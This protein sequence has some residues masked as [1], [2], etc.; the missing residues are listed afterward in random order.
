[1][2]DV[3]IVQGRLL[4]E[5]VA[6]YPLRNTL[7]SLWTGQHQYVIVPGVKVN[8]V[9]DPALVCGQDGAC[10]RPG[11]QNIYLVAGEPVQQVQCVFARDTEPANVGAVQQGCA[12]SGGAVLCYCVTEAAGDL[13][14]EKLDEGGAHE[15][16]EIV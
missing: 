11:R 14:V 2:A 13:P 9:N 8:Q 3:H 15:L 16:L 10:A 6:V 5:G 12:I 7:A 1:M 4:Q